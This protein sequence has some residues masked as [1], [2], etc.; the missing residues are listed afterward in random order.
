MTE[1]ALLL[2]QDDWDHLAEICSSFRL[3][4]EQILDGHKPVP[5]LAARLALC[6]RI[7]DAAKL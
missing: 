6:R 4:W 5:E 1:T 7:E 3:R 2:T